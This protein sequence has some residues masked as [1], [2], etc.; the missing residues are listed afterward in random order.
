MFPPI[1][2]EFGPP[3]SVF[4]WYFDS[5]APCGGECVA[6]AEGGDD[7]LVGPNKFGSQQECEDTC[8]SDSPLRKRDC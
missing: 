4:R 2:G 8:F 6:L 3:T 7:R 1:I 5:T